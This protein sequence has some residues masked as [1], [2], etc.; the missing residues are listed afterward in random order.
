MRALL[1][2]V[3][4]CAAWAQPGW[5]SALRGLPANPGRNTSVQD[6]DDFTRN[7]RLAAPYFAGLH[8]GDYEANREIMRQMLTY[9]TAVDAMRMSDPRMRSALS[10]AYLAI[11]AL[12]FGQPGW[13]PP[14]PGADANQPPPASSQPTPPPFALTAPAI[15]GITAED[16]ETADDLTGRYANT[17]RQAARAWKSAD[18]LRIR[19]EGQGMT[20]NDSTADSLAKMQLYFELAT[21]DLRARDWPNAKTNIDRA[22]YETEK[23][24][25]T[26]G[27]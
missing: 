16:K 23:V 22:G 21:E 18:E 3:A 20:L 7:V 1:V 6:I 15:E 24:F 19:L 14:P 13:A 17:A 4:C 9:V 2:L 5:R 12:N 8:P 11:A 25:R 10:R 27:R 26:V